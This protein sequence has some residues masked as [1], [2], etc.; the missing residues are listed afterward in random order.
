LYEKVAEFDLLEFMSKIR[1]FR[2]WNEV[3]F[4]GFLNDFILKKWSSLD[5][6]LTVKNKFWNDAIEYC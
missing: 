5:K 6:Q 3:W 1:L 2:Y 4:I